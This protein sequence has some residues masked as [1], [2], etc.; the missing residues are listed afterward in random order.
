MSRKQK[1][2]RS[3]H[4]VEVLS[5]HF[6]NAS[7]IFTTSPLYRTLCPFVARERPILEL[8]TERREGQQA[9]FLLFGAVHYLLL[10]G[11][12]HP[13]SSFYPSLVGETALEPGGVGPVFRRF[14]RDYRDD[15]LPIIRTRLIQTNVVKRVIGLRYALAAIAPRCKQP[16]HLIEIGSSAGIHL[17]FDQYKYVIG[18]HLY[19]DEDSPVCVQA[20]WRADQEP[21]N[22]NK[23]PLIASRVG[24]DLHPVNVRDERERLWLRALVWPEDKH[25]AALLEA[26]LRMLSSERPRLI[27]G[28]ALDVCP[29]LAA[30]LPFGEPR[31]VFHAATR[32]HVPEERRHLF[33]S[34]IDAV[35]H[36][37]PLFHVWQEPT[38]A[39]HHD[40]VADP[41]GAIE[42]H[43]PGDEKP[44]SLVLVDGHLEWLALPDGGRA[45]GS[46]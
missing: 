20:E 23:L 21:L 34:A 40:S 30:D 28:D 46:P 6:A 44:V 42:F 31:V 25:K 14:V 4:E 29:Q 8:L 43:G 39:P 33:D 1:Q 38:W 10:L 26:A 17:L 7:S 37:G 18:K 45:A 19:G 24:V 5:D 15:L 9:S 41:R 35:G 3:S 11:V 13:L 12:K 22:L 36:S 2:F 32:M 27:E 16:M